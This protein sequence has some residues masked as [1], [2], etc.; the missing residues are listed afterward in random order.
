MDYRPQDAVCVGIY[1]K[2][3][4]RMIEE[5]LQLLEESLRERGR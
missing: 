4:P 2:D 3:K 5:D 1:T